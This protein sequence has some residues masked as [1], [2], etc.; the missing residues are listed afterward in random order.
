[1]GNEPERRTI[2]RQGRGGLFYGIVMPER[3]GTKARDAQ[4]NMSAA[5]RAMQRHS[6]APWSAPAEN[7][8]QSLLTLADYEACARGASPEVRHVWVRARANDP[9]MP[10]GVVE[11]RVRGRWRRRLSPGELGRV[12]EALVAHNPIGVELRVQS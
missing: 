8:W 3:F 4:A 9:E 2:W 6:L 1:M 10:A 7:P 5:L 12:R 11:I